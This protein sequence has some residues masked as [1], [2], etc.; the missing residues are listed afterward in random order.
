MLQITENTMDYGKFCG[1]S[2]PI[3]RS[4]TSTVTVRS[5][6]DDTGKGNGGFHLEY[7]QE[8]I[9]KGRNIRIYHEWEGMIEKYVQRIALWHHEAC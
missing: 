1:T 8:S 3:I 5:K 6:T 4:E 2:T 9:C 7:S